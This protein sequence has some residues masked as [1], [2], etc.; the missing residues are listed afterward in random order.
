MDSN[1]K[2]KDKLSIGAK[3]GYG[4][5]AVGDAMA[6][7]F[8]GTYLLFFLTTVAGI[9]PAVAGT[10][11]VIAAVW[12]AVINPI[13]G[14]FSDH[15]SSRFGRRR[16]FMFA[17]V[18]PLMV[19]IVLLF[20]AVKITYEIK[21][22]YYC[23]M[24][25]A[26]WTSFTGFFVPYYALGAEYSENYDERTT[27]RSFASFFNLIGT[28]F[29]MALPPVI[30]DCLNKHGLSV[31]HAWTATA[32]MIAIIAG[33]SI[34]ITTVASK[35]YDVNII[36]VTGTKT[37]KLSLKG[38]IRDYVS[39]LKLKP[40]KYVLVACLFALIA[41]G[42][43]VSDF[44]YFATYK[45][46]LSGFET[47]AAMFFRCIVGICL[48]APAMMLCRKTDNRTALIIIFL[49]S[50]VLMIAER[51]IGVHGLATLGLFLIITCIATGTYWQIMPAIVYELCVYDEY[52]TGAKREGSIVSI[53]GLV[54]SIAQGLGA[55]ILGIIL[56]CTGFDGNAPAQSELTNTWII[57]C[58]TWV[59]VIFIL[60]AVFALYKYPISRKTF[61]EI[62]SKINRRKENS[63]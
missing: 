58:T 48:I 43:I 34:L 20:T 23:F 6:Y 3:C 7:T 49:L 31:S 27:L 10:I 29:S 8:T 4:C 55:Q 30:V 62:S 52:V 50:S 33:V 1:K 26:F 40:T 56:Q 2:S 13:I 44:M 12:D 37:E 24:A 35:K 38:M 11:T 46:G 42:M 22:V 39:V 60:I 63:I 21:V 51:F 15:F 9:K 36:S 41:Y 45:V 25:M 54:E 57:N 59:P 32:L 17:S 61:N 14:Y 53:Q 18:F 47:S 5:A 19:C 16:P 28:F